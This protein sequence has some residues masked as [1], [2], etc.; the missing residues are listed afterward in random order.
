MEMTDQSPSWVGEE[1]EP[2]EAIVWTHCVCLGTH[3]CGEDKE[4]LVYELQK[5]EN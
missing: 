2:G 5:R 1:T 4:S 3:G